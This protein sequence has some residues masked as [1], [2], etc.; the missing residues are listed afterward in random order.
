MMLQEVM[1]AHPGESSIELLRLYT[2]RLTSNSRLLDE[3][4]NRCFVEDCAE[5]RS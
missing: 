4:I 5:L 3:A 2:E 1:K